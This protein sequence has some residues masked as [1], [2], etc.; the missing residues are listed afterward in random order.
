M[1]LE[2]VCEHL[3]GVCT[4]VYR[5]FGE[6]GFLVNDIN[7]LGKKKWEEKKPRFKDSKKINREKRGESKI[8]RS[9]LKR[10][11]IRDILF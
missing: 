1:Y 10:L 9:A 6:C 8:Y 2:G 3:D 5:V 4:R 11:H 7:I